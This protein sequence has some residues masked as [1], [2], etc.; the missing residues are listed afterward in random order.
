MIT[1]FSVYDKNN[2]NISD[3]NYINV[4]ICIIP[5]DTNVLSR[6]H[7]ISNTNDAHDCECDDDICE[8][9]SIKSIPNILDMINDIQN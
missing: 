3:T 6:A 8:S 2:V 7:V 9:V 5:Y 1:N 4:D